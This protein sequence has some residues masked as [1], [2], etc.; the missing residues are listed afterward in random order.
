MNFPNSHHRLEKAVLTV[1]LMC[2]LGSRAAAI[3]V[4][5]ILWGFDG[6]CPP[7][8]FVPLNL[9]VF[10]ERPDEFRGSL[11]LK[12]SMAIGGSAGAPLVTPVNL[13]PGQRNWVKFYVFLDTGDLD[14][15]WSW[16]L[17][18]Q[19]SQFGGTG[20]NAFPAKGPRA[21]IVLV[22]RSDLSE[23][24]INLFKYPERLFPPTVTATDALDEVLLD[25]VPTWQRPQRLAFRDWLFRGGRVHIF[26]GPE[27]NFPRFPAPLDVLNDPTS[28]RRVGAGWVTHHSWNRDEAAQLESFGHSTDFEKPQQTA[29][30]PDALQGLGAGH[31]F[32]SRFREMVTPDFNWILIFLLG[33]AFLLSVFPG[34]WIMGIRRVDFRGVLGYLVGMILLFSLA[35]SVVG[36][37][38]YGEASTV[39]CV[40]IARSLD[41]DQ[42]DVTQWT[43][44]FVTDG[45]RYEVT[46]DGPGTQSQ[47]NSGQLYATPGQRP[48]QP[49]RRRND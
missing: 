31:E 18:W 26:H 17:R 4:E 47:R 10:N 3:E 33:G 2:S 23:W 41:D 8:S 43:G 11:T 6:T 46:H 30:T 16:S 15:T 12:K 13:A 21:R 22:D 25:H 19:G 36:A 49:G 9:L 32:F 34:G 37:R 24:K 27:G 38:G 7:R 35:F 48:Q 39:N 40:A 42:W 20:L 29:I 28:P 14:S 5:E 45:D 1:L 44:L